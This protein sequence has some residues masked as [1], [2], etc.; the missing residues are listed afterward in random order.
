[1]PISLSTALKKLESVSPENRVILQSFCDYMRLKDLKSEHHIANL[2]LLLISFDKFL[3]KDGLN[4]DF[5]S[6]NS[7]EQILKFL[8]HRQ[9]DGGKWG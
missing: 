8:N 5:T 3:C 1:M 6:I 9:V 7:R 4:Q 2:L